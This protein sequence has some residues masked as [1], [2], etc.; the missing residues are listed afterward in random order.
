MHAN[1]MRDCT[2]GTASDN[3]LFTIYHSLFGIRYSVFGISS[4]VFAVWNTF[5]SKYNEKIYYIYRYVLVGRQRHGRNDL[6]AERFTNCS[7]N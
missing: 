7:A 2:S 5:D 3:S 4:S 6:V 1:G